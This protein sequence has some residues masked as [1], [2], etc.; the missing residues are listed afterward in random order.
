MFHF[1][2]PE[3]ARTVPALA[4]RNNKLQDP[5]S[6]MSL[7]NMTKEP[8]CVEITRRYWQAV[9]EQ[10]WQTVAMLHPTSTAEEWEN[11]YSNSNFKQIIE[12]G[13]PYQ[14][15]GCT[16]VPCTIRFDSNVTRTINTT[17]IFRTI[18]G[19]QSCVIANTWSQDWG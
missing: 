10:D 15:D 12:I 1:E 16:I 2:I 6:G 11:K 19:Q 17:V 8:A 14:E 9:I 3:G 18:D 4:E 5:N 13:E 7:G